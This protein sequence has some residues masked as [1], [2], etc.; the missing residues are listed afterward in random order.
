M[1]YFRQIW[2]DISNGENIDLYFAVPLAISLAILNIFGVVPPQFIQ[3]LTLIVLGILAFSLLLNRNAVIKLSQEIYK[4]ADDV[5]MR[6]FPPDFDSNLEG[7]KEISLFGVTLT[8]FLRKNYFVLQKKLA[9]GHSIKVMIVDPE[10]KAIELAEERNIR[11]TDLD[12]ARI[13]AKATIKQ[14]C[15][16]REQALRM[17]GKLEVRTTQHPL[18]Y[19]AFGLDLNKSSGIIYISH[20]AFKMEPGSE[21]KLVLRV[22][23]GHWYDFYKTEINNMWNSATEWHYETS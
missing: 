15:H 2:N 21:P 22:K 19:A 3:P 5:F 14:L 9:S 6:A 11:P 23:D 8:D 4:K 18:N 12:Q 17:D 7:A 13:E 20:F 16:L 10:S 1:K